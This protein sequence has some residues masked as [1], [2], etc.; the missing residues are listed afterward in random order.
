M[1][2]RPARV[3]FLPV[4]FSHDL[5]NTR[6][7][8]TQTKMNQHTQA[9]HLCQYTE[10]HGHQVIY[11]LITTQ[12]DA[13]YLADQ[14]NQSLANRGIPGSVCSWYITGPHQ[15]TTGNN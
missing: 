3:F 12:W 10:R 4:V 14:Y 11:Q 9:F 8:E 5:C 1:N 15:Q 7:V 2:K 13:D 6:G